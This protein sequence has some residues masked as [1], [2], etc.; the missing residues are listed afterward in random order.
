MRTPIHAYSVVLGRVPQPGSE[1]GHSDGAR[2]TGPF[3]GGSVTTSGGAR[4]T[5]YASVG[6]LT[7]GVATLSATLIGPG[8]ALVS[9]A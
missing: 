9:S 1:A 3:D 4:S 2:S 8:N 6:R 5:E 7:S